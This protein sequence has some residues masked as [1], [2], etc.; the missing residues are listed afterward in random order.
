MDLLET[1]S[2]QVDGNSDPED[3]FQYA[4]EYVKTLIGTLSSE[5]LLFFYGRYKQSTIGPCNT[6]KPNF[7]DFTGKEKWNAWKAIGDMPKVLI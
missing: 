6:E 1:E 3:L 7:F 2:L 4:T 5:D